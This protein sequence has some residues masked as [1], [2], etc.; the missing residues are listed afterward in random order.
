[1]TPSESALTKVQDLYTMQLHLWDVLDT[2]ELT[3][4]QRDEARKHLRA[5]S[6]LLRQA[7]RG[8][9]GGEDVYDT[10]KHMEREVSEKLKAD[11]TQRK[12]RT[13]ARVGGRGKR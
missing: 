4:E 6:T 10:L 5:F 9:M 3:P 7:D 12:K 11:A 2:Q 13:G 1:M 8:I